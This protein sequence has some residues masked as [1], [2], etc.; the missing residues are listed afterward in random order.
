MR[1][2]AILIPAYN[3]A[4]VIGNTLASFL[5]IIKK[6]DIYV[7]NDGS[8]DK[9][10]LVAKKY[11]PNVLTVTNR[12][13]A[14]ALNTAISKFKLTQKY[15]YL[16]PMD[17]DTVI[18]KDFLKYTLPILDQDKGK[19]ICGV[20][21][22]VVGST[23]SWLTTYRLWEYEISQ[24]IHKRAQAHTNSV[25]VCPGCATV[26]RSELFKKIQIPQGTLTEDMDLTFLINRNKLGKI[27][28]CSKAIVVTQ[29]PQSLR[30]FIKQIYRWY[31]GFWQ[32][33]IKH[34]IPWGGQALDIEVAL[35][36][37]EGLFNGLLVLSLIL[38][39]PLTILNK[40][41]MLLIPASVDLFAFLLPTMMLTSIR[42]RIMKIYFYI[43]HFYFMRLISSVVF[44]I[45]FLKIV[46]GHDARAKKSW[47]TRR[48][49]IKEDKL[50]LNPSL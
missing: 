1:K 2:L 36:A 37:L 41:S 21:G 11:T 5:K 16:M 28:F 26:F 14:N 34:N 7:V 29:D 45:S 42:H 18:T 25:I 10:A 3:E 38:L 17:A 35:L 33:L 19:K 23:H 30:E 31:T 46:L 13:K 44:F 40:P 20:V 48:Y 8:K 32:C 4:E 47:N 39:L 50:W 24:T 43:P 49:L 12:G 6:E 22:K 15:K 9:T 27:E